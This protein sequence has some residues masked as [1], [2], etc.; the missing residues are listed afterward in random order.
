MISLKYHF[1]FCA[2]AWHMK[3]IAFERIESVKNLTMKIVYDITH[4]AFIAIY[5]QKT[6]QKKNHRNGKKQLCRHSRKQIFV[7]FYATTI[8]APR[9]NYSKLKK[10]R[11]KKKLFLNSIVVLSFNS[12]AVLR[13]AVHAVFWSKAPNT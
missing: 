2:K 1:A 3:R 4:Q 8:D 6:K 13:W 12:N 5:M 10:K 9:P 7:A 11:K